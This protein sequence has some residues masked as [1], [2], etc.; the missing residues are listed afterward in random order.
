MPSFNHGKFIPYAIKSVLNQDFN[1]FELII[2]DDASKDNSAE[3]IESFRKRDKR[4]RA[5][6]HDKN[7][8]IVKTYNEGINASQG[9]YI[10]II[11]SDDIWVE[12]KLTEQ[13]KVLDSNENL[14]V[15]SE[16]EIIDGEG[17]P[18]GE[19]FTEI[20]GSPDKKKSGHILKTL[21]KNNYILGSS[22]IAANKN[23]KKISF[24][25]K[26]KYLN[27][28]LFFTELAKDYEYF[29]IDK[30]LVKYR[31]HGTNTNRDSL[32]FLKDYLKIIKIF[33]SKY[34]S[35]I[36]KE[37]KSSWYAQIAALYDKL[38]LKLYVGFYIFK[39]FLVDIFN[40][41]ARYNLIARLKIRHYFSFR[42]ITKL[43]FFY[44]KLNFGKDNNSVKK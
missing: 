3:I 8:G 16:G 18:T 13:I 26:L 9:K 12:N 2:I 5:V 11:D 33:I 43:L 4:I 31:I 25:D 44:R 15:W 23:L 30:L 42:I 40:T 32:G 17:N 6:Y 24:C 20:H 38:G 35:C 37:I 7:K 27:D 28:W 10:A 41:E 1:D 34:K 19:K 14:I 39:R 29:L 22:L 36:S 21:L